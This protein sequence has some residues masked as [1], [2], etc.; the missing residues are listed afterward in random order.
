[1]LGSVG[2]L[3][4]FLQRLFF[5]EKVAY[6]AGQ[7]DKE[8]QQPQ[9]DLIGGFG[10]DPAFVAACPGLSLWQVSRPNGQTVEVQSVSAEIVLLQVVAIGVKSRPSKAASKTRGKP[11]LSIIH[12]SCT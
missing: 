1:M 2:R 12:H 5:C 10:Y 3:L 6:H 8:C 11:R 7:E 4:G 9:K